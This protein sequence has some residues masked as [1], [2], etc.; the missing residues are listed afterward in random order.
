VALFTLKKTQ[1]W[2]WKAYCRDIN[3]L[4]D[5][6]CGGRDTR[7]FAQLYKRLLKWNV[8]VYFSDK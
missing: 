6:Q 7:T 5:W 1:I 8:E 3:Q 2:I 4:I